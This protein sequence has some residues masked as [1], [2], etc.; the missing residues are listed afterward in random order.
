MPR[1][2][3]VFTSNVD[4]HFQRAGYPEDRIVEHHGSIHHL[5]CMSPC[6]DGLWP[7]DGVHVEVDPESFEA[8]E[9]YPKCSSCGGLARPNVLMFG[10]WEW[11][12][13]RAAA[14][15]ERF[16]KWLDENGRSIV[17]VEIGAGTAIPTVRILSEQT[18]TANGS[19]LIRIN[20]REPQVPDGGIEIAKPA[21]AALREIDKHLP[22][23]FRA[24]ASSSNTEQSWIRGSR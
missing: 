2:F 6:H 14:Q 16:K 13:E 9:P 3:F 4:G 12:E 15:H 1:G 23:R 11:V 18:A 10:D 21:L 17:V 5:Q 22:A 7:A 20:P 24:A 19:E 8:S